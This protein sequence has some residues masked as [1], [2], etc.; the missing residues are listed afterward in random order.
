M[1]SSRPASIR[2]ADLPRIDGHSGTGANV[3]KCDRIHV[4]VY[5]SDEN[6]VISAPTGAGKTVSFVL[7]RHGKICMH[8]CLR[9]TFSSAGSL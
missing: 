3:P 8:R 9:L 7:R 5:G 4:Q 1:L 6:V 2:C